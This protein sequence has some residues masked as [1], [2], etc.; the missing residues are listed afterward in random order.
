MANYTNHISIFDIPALLD[1]I[2]DN[3]SRYQVAT[4]LQV[5]RSWYD[6]FLPQINRFVK[7]DSLGD[8]QAQVQSILDRAAVIRSLEIRLSDGAWFLDKGVV[9]TNLRRL[10]CLDSYDSDSSPES[11]F[12]DFPNTTNSVA[13]VCKNPQLEILHIQHHRKTASTKHFTPSILE[14]L[15]FHSSLTQ[16][17][18]RIVEYEIEFLHTLV[19]HLPFSLQELE[20]SGLRC[21]VSPSIVQELPLL[22]WPLTSLRKLCLHSI[23]WGLFSDQGSSMFWSSIF[24]DRGYL[25]ESVVVPLVAKCPLLQEFAIGDYKGDPRVVLQALTDSCP[26]LEIVNLHGSD[27]VPPPLDSS[28]T[29]TIT[30]AGSTPLR[31]RLAKLREFRLHIWNQNRVQDDYQNLADWVLR[32]A[33]TL[34]IIKFEM[35]DYHWNSIQYP[36]SLQQVIK[37]DPWDSCSW[38]DCSRLRKFRVRMRQYHTIICCLNCDDEVDTRPPQCLPRALLEDL[39]RPSEWQCTELESLDLLVRDTPPPQPTPVSVNVEIALAQENEGPILL[40]PVETEQLRQK[41]ACNI[42]QLFWR[43]KSLPRLSVLKLK[44]NLSEAVTTVAL[45]DLL[46]MI[47]RDILDAEDEG[48]SSD[49]RCDIGKDECEDMS[50]VEV[51]IGA[52]ATRQRKM[53]YEDLAWLG[54]GSVFWTRRE[55]EIYASENLPQEQPPRERPS[56]EFDCPEHPLYRR[57]GHGWRDWDAV[58]GRDDEEY[59]ECDYMEDPIESMTPFGVMTKKFEGA[60]GFWGRRTR[61]KKG[62]RQGECLNHQAA[63]SERKKK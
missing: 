28:E 35:N 33:S 52:E 7:F 6:L 13:L 56:H 27:Y 10:Y 44:W 34:D 37:S 41:F 60:N 39:V 16:I 42:R 25:P 49:E 18:I 3:L 47:N 59:P 32:S 2:C 17:K 19:Q 29:S 21:N 57:V 12:S 45:E 55:Y 53:K 58:A 20:F 62:D 30:V 50:I 14:S 48:Q 9:C 23:N 63:R 8:S 31:G 61:A 51:D 54:L 4:C 1:S 38:I 22:D 26:D 24:F 46:D 15:F 40:T 11:D 43:L 5:S 36:W